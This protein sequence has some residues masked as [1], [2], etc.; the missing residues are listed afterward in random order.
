MF[1]DTATGVELNVDLLP[2]CTQD[3]R[4]HVTADRLTVLLLPV[5]RPY[6][7]LLVYV[8]TTADVWLPASCI[9]SYYM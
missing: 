1:T 5:I 2:C 7:F 8:D 6:H 9:A 4:V 3:I